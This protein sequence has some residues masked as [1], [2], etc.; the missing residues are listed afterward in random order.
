[1]LTDLLHHHVAAGTVAG[2][3]ALLERDGTRE[4][5][6]AGVADLASGRP[7]T[8]ATV[9]R[10]ASLTKPVTAAAAMTFVQDGALGLG[11]PV[12]RWLPELR[13]VRV[14]RDPD[15]DLRDTV[16]PQ[17]PITVED[18]LVSCTG[19]G[20]PSR[21]DGAWVE[22]L[23]R[24]QTGLEI[25]RLPP[26]P[27]WT[28]GLA[29]VPLRHQP[30]TTYLYG[31]SYDL[32]GVLLARVAGRPL[33]DVVA[34]RVTGPLGMRDT[35]F[36]VRADQRDRFCAAYRATPAGLEL[37]DGVDGRWSAPPRFP[38][39]GGG[40]VG[41]LGDQAAFARELHGGGRVLSPES[42]QRMTTDQLGPERAGEG[43]LFLDGHG[44]GFGGSVDPATGRY[45]WVGG[46]GTS[47]HVTPA[48]GATAVLLTQTVLDSP[49]PPAFLDD[50]AAYAC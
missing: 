34:D 26:P 35:G 47:A 7:V 22:A 23:S 16:A 29:T 49:V 31:T 42:L 20:F 5:A 17:R 19:W 32:L 28:A 40:L 50:F 3:V 11:D 21:F 2:A 12:E 1:M 38:S 18:V 10:W 6:A 25:T 13:D 15:A 41:T 14:L 33:P 39:G 36:A 44:W 8:P 43:Q 30:G 9:F 24:W 46:T 27:E 48:T 37:F 45:G 4:V